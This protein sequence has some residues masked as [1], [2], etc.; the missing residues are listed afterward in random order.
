MAEPAPID[1]RFSDL[2]EGPAVVLVHGFPI[3]G[4]MW[5]APGGI[6]AERFRVIVPDQRGFGGTAPS[7]TT[8]MATYADDLARLLD[9]LGIERPA[10]LAG[11][12]FGGYVVLEFLRRHPHRVDALGLI[13]TREVGDSPEGAAGRRESADRLDAGGP[14]SAVVDAMLPALI[15]PDPAPGFLEHWRGVMSGQDPV[16]VAAALRALAERPDSTETL[17]A[18]AGRALVVV[19]EHDAITPVDVHERMAGLLADAEL[20]VIP[21]CGHMAPTERPGEFAAIVRRFLGG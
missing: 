10:L 9:R 14:V 18:F 4:S 5:D 21:G 2:G 6:L 16:G 20:H 7:P 11:L 19:G 12:S 3:E 17:R 1:V 8:T 15:G 13:D